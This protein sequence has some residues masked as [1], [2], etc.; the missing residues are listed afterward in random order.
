MLHKSFGAKSLGRCAASIHTREDQAPA[1][2]VHLWPLAAERSMGKH[3]FACC[4]EVW[5][6]SPSATSTPATWSVRP[7]ASKPFSAGLGRI[8]PPAL[9]VAGA[10]EPLADTYLSGSSGI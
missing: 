5:A 6:S 3:R 2:H 9:I 8:P 7:P 10:A 4:V 1:I